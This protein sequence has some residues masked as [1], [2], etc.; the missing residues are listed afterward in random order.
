MNTHL[1]EIQKELDLIRQARRIEDASRRKRPG[2]KIDAELKELITKWKAASRLAAEELF[3][4]VKGRV[5]SMGG[6]EAW[7]RSRRGNAYDD[8]DDGEGRGVK[9]VRDSEDEEHEA[10][11]GEG[12]EEGREGQGKEGEGNEE[13]FTML[14]MLRSL[15]IEPEVLGWD[16][17]E[18]KW[19]D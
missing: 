11:E 6:G 2:E 1:D 19:K 12:D 15:N 18:E 7:R 3:E 14:M 8:H 16:E 17:G 5:E 9:R 10:K 4:L 13:G